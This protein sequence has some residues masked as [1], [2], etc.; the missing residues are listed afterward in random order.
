MNRAISG[1]A[2]Q[3][4]R[5]GA[6]PGSASRARSEDPA[7]GGDPLRAAGVDRHD[8]QDGPILTDPNG[9]ELVLVSA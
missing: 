3:S 9:Q 1:E 4:S 8:S 7:R 2:N 5:S 6:A